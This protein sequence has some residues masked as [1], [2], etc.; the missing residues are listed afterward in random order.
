MYR[1]AD[2][3]H[4][5]RQLNEWEQWNEALHEENYFTVVIIIAVDANDVAVNSI[6]IERIM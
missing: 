5:I 4:S 3:Q 1:R 6:K 2:A